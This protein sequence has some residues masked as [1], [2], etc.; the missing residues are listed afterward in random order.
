MDSFKRLSA[1]FISLQLAYRRL[2]LESHPDRTG[3]ATDEVFKEIQDAYSVLSDPLRRSEYD[4]RSRFGGLSG[5]GGGN[6]GTDAAD[7]ASAQVLIL[8]VLLSAISLLALLTYLTYSFFPLLL[9]LLLALNASHTGRSCV[10]PLTLL[11]LSFTS[12]LLFV[13]AWIAVMLAHLEQMEWLFWGVG[14]A[15]IFSHY[16]AVAVLVA[17]AWTI[18]Q[19]RLGQRMINLS[20]VLVVL[21][22]LVRIVV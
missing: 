10:V 17:L 9:L 7:P 5:F 21:K 20:P 18:E 11:T 1:Q 15:A 22:V 3:R 2:A 8:G 19:T 13:G 14:Y 16:N 12:G 4:W 6:G